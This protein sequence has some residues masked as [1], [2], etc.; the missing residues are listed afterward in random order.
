MS[1]S[2]T[3]FTLTFALKDSDKRCQSYN[4]S[5]EGNDESVNFEMGQYMMLTVSQCKLEKHHKNTECE[6]DWGVGQMI[7]PAKV[8]VEVYG[9]DGYKPV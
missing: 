6:F 2:R 7:E 5:A 9:E 8:R 4:L 3:I 1:K